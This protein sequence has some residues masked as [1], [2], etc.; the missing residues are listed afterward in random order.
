MRRVFML[1]WPMVLAQMHMHMHV[2]ANLLA[3]GP[4]CAARV[5]EDAMKA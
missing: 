3:D 4:A 5:P 2:R 1:S